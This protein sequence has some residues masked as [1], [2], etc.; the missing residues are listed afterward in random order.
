M[1]RRPDLASL[2]VPGPSSVHGTGL[3]ARRPIG[4]GAL[5]G[6]YEGTPTDLDGVHVLWV[7]E[8]TETWRGID[9]TG[10]L[11]WLNHSRSPNVEFDGPELHA[12]TDIAEGDELL[13]DY[14]EEW[15]DMP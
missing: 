9:G 2:V 8:D 14:G 13:F 6:T 1:A 10:L 7:E 5:I 12:L 3:F 15:A 11:R 4:A